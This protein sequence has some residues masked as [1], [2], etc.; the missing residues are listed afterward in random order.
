MKN[1]VIVGEEALLFGKTLYA[2]NINLI[3]C[4]TLDKPLRCKAK[5]RY[6]QPEQWATA[7]QSDD[8]TLRVTF[9]Q[10]QRAITPG[11]AV[12]LYDGECVIGGGTIFNA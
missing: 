8:S 2:K 10:P 4:D 12:V 5:I 11:Q 7:E 3:A 9:D 6:R 1:T